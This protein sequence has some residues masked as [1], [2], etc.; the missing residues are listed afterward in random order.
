VSAFDTIL[1]TGL[2]PVGLGAIVNAR[3]RGAR[4]IAVESVSWRAERARTMGA[5]TVV[6]PHD[7]AALAQ[8]MQL[9]DGRG[10]DCALDCSGNVQAERLCV[11]A[12]RRKGKVA[13][14]GECNDELSV[15]ISPDMIRKGL[16]LVGSWHYNLNEYPKIMQVIQES[17]LI[18]HLISH[19]QRLSFQRRMRRPRSSFSR[20][21]NR[22]WPRRVIQRNVPV[23]SARSSMAHRTW[24]PCSC[25]FHSWLR[26]RASTRIIQK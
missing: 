17:P 11:D 5:A 8:I 24:V 21:P 16:T 6:D 20:G 3:F 23:V 26:E 15:R 22:Y 10:V 7:E 2:G 13:F 1:I 14:I 12:T 4:I 9:T 25:A 18:D 19:R